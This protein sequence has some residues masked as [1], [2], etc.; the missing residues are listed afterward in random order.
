MGGVAAELM[1]GERVGEYPDKPEADRAGSQ[2][3]SDR[4]WAPAKRSI[5]LGKKRLLREGKI[6]HPIWS[7]AG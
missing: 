1:R 3:I 2:R 7:Q 5:K 4:Q 6:L